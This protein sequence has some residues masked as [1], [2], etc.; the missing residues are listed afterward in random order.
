MLV[1]IRQYLKKSLKIE[2][3]FNLCKQVIIHWRFPLTSRLQEFFYCR[4]I[5]YS[6]F[7]SLGKKERKRE[8][9]L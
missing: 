1:E 3:F 9:I 7:E 4:N 5:A 6:C 2:Y 8:K